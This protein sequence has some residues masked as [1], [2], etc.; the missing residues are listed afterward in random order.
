MCASDLRPEGQSAPALL[1]A[2]G[3]LCPHVDNA[4]VPRRC[5]GPHCPLTHA[6]WP[7]ARPEQGHQ[8]LRLVPRV[9]V[10][11]EMVVFVFCG[12]TPVATC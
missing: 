1:V 8:L 9:A 3:P 2:R 11:Q 7:A 6:L 12:C 10:C 5:W 4:S